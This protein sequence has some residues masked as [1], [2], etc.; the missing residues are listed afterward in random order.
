MHVQHVQAPTILLVFDRNQVRRAMRILVLLLMSAS[1]C[2]LQIQSELDA[3]R[4]KSRERENALRLTTLELEKK[5]AESVEKNAAIEQEKVEQAEAAKKTEEDLRR[6]YGSSC[7][8]EQ[9]THVI[10]SDRSGCVNAGCCAQVVVDRCPWPF[11]MRV[12]S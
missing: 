5:L 6:R 8:R 1:W 11:I 12:F 2:V 7:C 10:S 9:S 3:T 4:R